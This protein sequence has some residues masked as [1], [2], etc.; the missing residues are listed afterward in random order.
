MATIIVK[1]GKRRFISQIMV[2]GVKRAKLFPDT[3]MESKRA[4]MQWELETKKLLEQESTATRCLSI[5]VW[6]NEYLDEVHARYSQKT[7][8]EKR[9]AFSR[10]IKHSGYAMETPV[11]EI[12]RDAVRAFPPAPVKYDQRSRGQQGTQK[13]RRS[14]AMG[15]TQ[16]RRLA[17]YAQPIF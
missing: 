15:R 4:A 7:Y 6:I 5:I 14:L 3:S 8:D 17:Q 12:K 10:F 13:F 9:K 1:R 11:E 2:N 16:Y